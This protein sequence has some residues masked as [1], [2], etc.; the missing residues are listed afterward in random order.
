M[1]HVTMSAAPQPRALS[2][3][4]PEIWCVKG[5][6]TTQVTWHHSEIVT[7]HADGSISGSPVKD[8]DV[9]ASSGV[10]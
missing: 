3:I 6:V 8:V 7:E 1:T 4:Q 5:L 9:V 2:S 10:E